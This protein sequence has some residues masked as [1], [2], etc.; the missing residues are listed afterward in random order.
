MAL[1]SRHG[2]ATA[3]SCHI[4]RGQLWSLLGVTGGCDRWRSG[5][6]SGTKIRGPGRAWAG[7]TRLQTP[8][9]CLV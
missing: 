9:M 6:R 3:V 7:R 5:G 4:A 8:V 2:T 1:L